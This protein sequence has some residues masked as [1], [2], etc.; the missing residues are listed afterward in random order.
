M[1]AI[2]VYVLLAIAV[3]TFAAPSL[4]AFVAPAHADCTTWALGTDVICN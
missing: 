4:S 1:K 3:A 2:I